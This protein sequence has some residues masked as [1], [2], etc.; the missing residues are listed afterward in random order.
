MDNHLTQKLLPKHIFLDTVPRTLLNVLRI[1]T[2]SKAV[3]L[4]LGVY[5]HLL[6]KDLDCL[7]T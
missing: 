4:L 7:F 6:H 5:Q 2:H 1:L 3:H